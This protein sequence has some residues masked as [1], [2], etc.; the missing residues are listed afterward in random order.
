MSR[1]E[2]WTRLQ[3]LCRCGAGLQ[4]L[5]PDLCALLRQW[6]GAD[7]VA[8]FWL[9]A[10]GM[11]EGFFHEDS[12][13]AVQALF[14][15]EFERLFVG[16]DEI[17]VLA[18]AQRK[19]AAMGHLVAPQAS[20][21][22]SNTFNL[23]VRPSGHRHCL[24]LRVEAQ[25]R[26]RAVVLLFRAPGRPFGAVEAACLRQTLPALRQAIAQAPDPTARPG[27]VLASGHL[28]VDAAGQQILWHDAS[29]LGLLGQANLVGTGY[30]KTRPLAAPPPLVTA[31]CGALA[32]G[33]PVA[34][35]QHP[36]PGGWLRL[37]ARAMQPGTP[38]APA[39][40]LV[41]LEQWQ[42]QSLDV[43]RRVA[44]LPLSP[45]Q[46]EISLLAGLGH[47]RA[48]CLQELG[49][50]NEALKKHLKAI[51]ATTGC[52]D[53]GELRQHLAASA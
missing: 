3:L 20:Y 10:Q 35:S 11:P 29:A 17:N 40:V 26:A 15:D 22:R 28:L 41:S 39:A 32:G 27:Q 50:S 47:A 9:D 13:A 43:A 4:A 8:L 37:E 14:L 45:L 19:D 42:P 21:F 1:R 2:L 34:L 5:A 31:L 52:A 25:G 24:D 30:L 36:V 33:Q 7:A 44:A 53:W 18:L 46:R 48:E 51:Y 6:V 49:V 16:P 38:G 12:P 23:L